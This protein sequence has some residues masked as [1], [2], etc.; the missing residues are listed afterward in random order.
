MDNVW[1]ATNENYFLSCHDG[2]CYVELYPRLAP[3]YVVSAD[4]TE[5]V[6]NHYSDDNS[7]DPL[8]CRGLGGWIHHLESDLYGWA[9]PSEYVVYRI[10]LD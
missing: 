2:R 6:P 1:G 5:L 9:L 8:R 10:L 7:G 3:D 4:S